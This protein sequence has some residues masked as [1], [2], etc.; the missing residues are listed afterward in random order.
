MIAAIVALAAG[1]WLVAHGATQA[2]GHRQDHL[3][4]TW[5]ADGEQAMRT[6]NYEV[7][8]VDL[9][10]ALAYSHDSPQVRL[11]LAEALAAAGSIRQAQAYLRVLWEEQPGDAT[12]NLQLARLAARTGDLASAERY[13]NDA[14][15]GVWP[16]GPV[17][18]R[19]NTRLELVRYLLARDQFQRAQSQLIAVAADEPSDPQLTAEIGRMFLQA[20]DAARARQQ[21]QLTIRKQPRNAAALA[22]AGEAA[23]QLADY[24]EARRYLQRAI[25]LDPADSRSADLLAI[26]NLVLQLDPYAPRIG[27]DE[28]SR[29]VVADIGRTL[30]RLT[31]CAAQ[32]NIALTVQPGAASLPAPAGQTVQLLPNSSAQPPA[33]PIIADYQQLTA[34]QKQAT[35]RALN[36]NADMVDS[37]MDLVF[38]SQNDAANVCGAPEDDDFAIL[39]I[40]RA[41]GGAQ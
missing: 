7:A 34:M 11:R 30:N 4:R 31:A 28:R 41:N 36:A 29:R 6:G 35:V 40:G 16:E 17:E 1:L 20:G 33:N 23:F 14:I 8:V 26:S 27:R 24:P 15:Y 38:R 13:Y 9:R 37:A 10:T 3:A 25:A 32:K 22:G 18:N 12:V 2:Y 21:F 19:R 39:L 5:Y